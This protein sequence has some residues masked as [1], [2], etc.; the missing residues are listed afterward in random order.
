MLKFLFISQFKLLKMRL[1]ILNPIIRNNYCPGCSF[2][3]QLFFY[4]F[5]YCHQANRFV[6]CVNLY[7]YSCRINASLQ[8]VYQQQF[9]GLFSRQAT[10]LSKEWRGIF[11]GLHNINFL[12]ACFSFSFISHTAL[13][14]QGFHFSKLFHSVVLGHGMKQL[15]VG[16]PLN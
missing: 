6:T 1:I 15:K 3:P 2:F 12:H 13:F 8:A 11:T 7:K 9:R 5:W 4:L 10:P 14:K 16:I